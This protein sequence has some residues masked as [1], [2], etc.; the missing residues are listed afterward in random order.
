MYI[1]YYK[2]KIEGNEFI[3]QNINIL[4]N[5]DERIAIELRENFNEMRVDITQQI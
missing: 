2:L 4:H 5:R 3:Q 1:T